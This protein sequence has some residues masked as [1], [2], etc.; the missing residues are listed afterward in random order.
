[1]RIYQDKTP[2]RGHQVGSERKNKK[3]QISLKSPLTA[4]LCNDI[5]ACSVYF[6]VTSFCLSVCPTV[7][8]FNLLSTIFLNLVSSLSPPSQ[9]DKC[10][11]LFSIAWGSEYQI[12]SK[13]DAGNSKSKGPRVNQR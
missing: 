12:C 8:K 3:K 4:I 7:C 6:S 10:V 13:L 11:Y 1:M 9:P 2:K 5:I